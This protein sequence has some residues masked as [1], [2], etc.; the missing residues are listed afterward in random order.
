[1][2]GELWFLPSVV[3]EADGKAKSHCHL[4]VSSVGLGPE[5]LLWRANSLTLPNTCTVASL[6]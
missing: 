1:M 3:G 6:G 2:G 5:N 4:S